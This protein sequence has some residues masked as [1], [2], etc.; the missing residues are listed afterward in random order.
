MPRV[1]KDL[2]FRSEHALGSRVHILLE[3]LWRLLSCACRVNTCETLAPL[4]F[5]VLAANL[6]QC[7]SSACVKYGHQCGSMC[8]TV[9][10]PGPGYT[11]LWA[12][13]TDSI[14]E[15]HCNGSSLGKGWRLRS[16]FLFWQ[17]SSACH[18]ADNTSVSRVTSKLFKVT[19]IKP[20]GWFYIPFW[21]IEKLGGFSG[22]KI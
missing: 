6:Q 17:V 18:V 8:R 4:G 13:G 7:Y 9:T 11:Q 19:F 21:W 16:I 14:L 15:L 12:R 22:R 3:W 1:A 2:G 10:T 20:T 5:G